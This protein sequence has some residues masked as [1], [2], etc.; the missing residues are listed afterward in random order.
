MIELAKL[1]KI[2]VI[3]CS[4]L[5]AYDFSWHKGLEPAEKIIE[6]NKMLKAYADRNRITY[7]DYHSK[8]ADE[9]NGLPEKYSGDGV[10]PNAEGYKVME[11]ILLPVLKRY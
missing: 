9:R 8:M 11:N 7:V 5:P 10:H 4:V 6:L 3:L 1:H 2:D